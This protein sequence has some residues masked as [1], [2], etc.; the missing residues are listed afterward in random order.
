MSHTANDLPA[1][2]NPCTESKLVNE[3]RKTVVA[4]VKRLTREERLRAFESTS[5]GGDVGS[6]PR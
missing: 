4:A 3:K 6:P 2:W 1:R 5:G